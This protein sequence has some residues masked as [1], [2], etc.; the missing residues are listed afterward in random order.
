M[1]P[2]SLPRYTFL[3]EFMGAGRSG[4]R[5]P[6][7]GWFKKK[8]KKK[9]RKKEKSKNKGSGLREAEGER[10]PGGEVEEEEGK[11]KNPFGRS[12]HLSGAIKVS[13]E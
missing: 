13:C 12:V 9:E 4:K 2:L 1:M 11:K 5:L 10:E 8:K 7:Q 6:F 3:S